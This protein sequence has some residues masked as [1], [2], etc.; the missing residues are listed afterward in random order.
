[1]EGPSINATYR[2]AFP[3]PDDIDS[4]D[5]SDEESAATDDVGPAVPVAR[6]T[7]LEGEDNFESST[8][9]RNSSVEAIE[10]APPAIAIE[11]ASDTSDSSEDGF[12]KVKP[13]LSRKGRSETSTRTAATGDSFKTAPETQSRHESRKEDKEDTVDDRDNDDVFETDEGQ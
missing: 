5:A 1:L 10:G 6:S 4:N 3:Q 13:V 11:D 12:V 2:T 7:P 8:T 9:L